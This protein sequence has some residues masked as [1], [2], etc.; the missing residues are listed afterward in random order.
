MCARLQRHKKEHTRVKAQV[1]SKQLECMSPC[2]MIAHCLGVL[3]SLQRCQS[4]R[5]GGLERVLWSSVSERGCMLWVEENACSGKRVMLNTVTW[6]DFIKDSL[7]PQL[8]AD[9]AGG[10]PTFLKELDEIVALVRS[11]CQDGFKRCKM[12]LTR[13]QV[14]DGVMT[15]HGTITHRL[16]QIARPQDPTC[17]SCGLTTST[18]CFKSTRK[19]AT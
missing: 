16:T 2:R 1:T 17:L 8:T 5:C 15:L 11:D 3:R 14:V 12:V 18:L 7:R 4:L 6:M 13:Q 10:L 9:P 19:L